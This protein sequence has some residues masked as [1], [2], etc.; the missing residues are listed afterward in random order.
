MFFCHIMVDRK[1]RVMLLFN[2]FDWSTQFDRKLH[3]SPV[4]EKSVILH[5][6]Q[7]KPFTIFKKP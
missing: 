7:P 1:K 2:L 4:L 6:M 3:L 5:S